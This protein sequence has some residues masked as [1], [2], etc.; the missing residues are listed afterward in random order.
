M[1]SLDFVR[2]RLIWLRMA[3]VLSLANDQRLSSLLVP[4]N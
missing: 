2:L 1:D 3:R 4:R